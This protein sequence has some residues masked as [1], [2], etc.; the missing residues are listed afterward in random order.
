MANEAMAPGLSRRDTRRAAVYKGRGIGQEQ[1]APIMHHIGPRGTGE[2]A[3][4]PTGCP[5]GWVGVGVRWAWGRQRLSSHE[6]R[7]VRVRV[8]VIN[9]CFKKKWEARVVLQ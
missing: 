9:I 6:P 3:R 8:R 7:H 1:C 4:V 2:S 5:R